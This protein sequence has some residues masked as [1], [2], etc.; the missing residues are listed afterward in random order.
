[1]SLLLVR[2][3]YDSCFLENDFVETVQN[4]HL[5]VTATVDCERSWDTLAVERAWL[6]M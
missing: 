2:D 3:C 4:K 6:N 1:M 5:S